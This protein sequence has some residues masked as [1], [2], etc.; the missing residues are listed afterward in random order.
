MGRGELERVRD[1]AI[2]KINE[3]SEPPWSW[4]QLMKLR[5][6]VEAILAGMA[7]TQPMEDSQ[8]PERRRGGGLRLVDSTDQ[9]DSAQDH[10]PPIPL[11]M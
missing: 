3:G 7:V 11:P 6:A 4:Y 10:Q 8:R 5:E 2:A 9:Q 1:W